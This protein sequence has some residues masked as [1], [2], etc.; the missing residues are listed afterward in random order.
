VRQDI[1]VEISALTSRQSVLT[2][3][4]SAFQR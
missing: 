1:A 4:S 3:Q 2:P